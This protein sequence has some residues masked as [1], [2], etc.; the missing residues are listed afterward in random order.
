[1]K[2]LQRIALLLTVFCIPLLTYGQGGPPRGGSSGNPDL[3]YSMSMDENITC[4]EQEYLDISISITG[5]NDATAELRIYDNNNLIYTISGVRNWD[6]ITRRYY[7][8]TSYR[9][10][11]PSTNINISCELIIY[12]SAGNQVRTKASGGCLVVVDDCSG[13]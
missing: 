11:D 10:C 7:P 1:M 8:S 5:T 12:D 4:S 2:Y 13:C 3:N 9:D 6:I